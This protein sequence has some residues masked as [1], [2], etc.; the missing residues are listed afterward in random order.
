MILDFV[1]RYIS[2]PS[3]MEQSEIDS[4]TVLLQASMESRDVKT[5]QGILKNLIVLLVN[6]VNDLPVWFYLDNP[7]A[8]TIMLKTP[9][10]EEEKDIL[11]LEFD[12]VFA[13]LQSC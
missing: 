5:E 4:F 3:V 7:N 13:L 11:R 6:K 1:S 12:D 2:S 8:K 9:T 10:K